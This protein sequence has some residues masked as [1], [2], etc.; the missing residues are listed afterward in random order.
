[1][2]QKYKPM[3]NLKLM[4]IKRG[5]TLESLAQKAGINYN[6]ILQYEKG[7]H[8]PR[9]DNLKKIAKALECDLEEI[10]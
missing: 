8:Q 10:V 7:Y 9:I 2:Q 3:L 4:R 6:T 1:M 5:L